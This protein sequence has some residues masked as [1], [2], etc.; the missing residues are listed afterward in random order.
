[1]QRLIAE[2]YRLHLTRG[3]EKMLRFEGMSRVAG[4]DEAGRGSLAGPVVAAAVIPDPQRLVPG[5]DDSK[6]L[7]S[8][9]R[10]EL[11]ERVKES[12]LAWSVASVSAGDIDRVN[13]LEAT[14]LAMH[15]CIASLS[16]GPDC[17][18]VDAVPLRTGIPTLPVFRGE[19]LSYSI[20]C[21]SIL[22]KV[23]RDSRMVDLDPVY[24]MYGFS[25][26]KG[27]GARQHLEALEVYGPSPIH[28]LTFRSVV[29]RLDGARKWVSA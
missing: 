26:N 22:A 28:R 6:R 24:P 12:S 10:E 9:L 18:L 25:A 29:P 23:E 2:A 17:V 15:T 13:V 19:S 11:A 21:A 3:L 5:V 16:P 8:A 4:V 20:A 14:R 7:S 1:M 27:Y